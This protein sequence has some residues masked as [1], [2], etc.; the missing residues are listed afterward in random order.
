MQRQK[1]LILMIFVSILTASMSQAKT[2]T[3]NLD[4]YKFESISQDASNNDYLEMNYQT[5]SVQITAPIVLPSEA[6]SS[7]WVSYDSNSATKKIDLTTYN[8]KLTVLKSELSSNLY[9]A[10]YMIDSETDNS[11]YMSDSVL[12]QGLKPGFNILSILQGANIDIS[13]EH[14]MR[15]TPEVEEI[16]NRKTYAKNFVNA[17]LSRKD[18]V[19]DLN[20]RLGVIS[21][22]QSL[23][24]AIKK[25]ADKGRIKPGQ[26][27]AVGFGATNFDSHVKSVCQLN[28]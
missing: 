15:I 2:V 14:S 7:G 13:T 8:I 27:I 9:K 20:P 28:P 26:V 18:K 16:V 21:F 17:L 10:S 22:D 3:C 19:G 4:F 5:E 12:L 24:K 25:N 23:L 11:V 1:V 6:L